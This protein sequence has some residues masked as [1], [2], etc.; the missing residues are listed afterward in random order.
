[1]NC[2]IHSV[3]NMKDGNLYFQGEK[4]PPCP[5]NNNNITVINDKI[6]VGGYEWTGT[7]WKRTARAIWHRWF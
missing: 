5:G 4:L 3:F 2:V 1:M 6:Y 7:Q